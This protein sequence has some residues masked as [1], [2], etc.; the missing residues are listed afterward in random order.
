M[1][2]AVAIP[3]ITTAASVG[4]TLVGAKMGSNAA[5]N[6]ARTQTDAA[7]RAAQLQYDLGNRSLDFQRQMWETG[8]NDMMPWMNMGRSA[9]GTLGS[10]MGLGSGG[11][12]PMGG[13]EPRSVGYGQTP[14]AAANGGGSTL[15]SLGQGGYAGP[16]MVQMKAPNGE[17]RPVPRTMVEH[18]KAR[19]AQVVG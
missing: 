9:L 6:A 3:L 4:G 12:P 8:R 13:G 11:G 15:G 1:P 14:N 16:Q 17:V 19:G 10:R 5:N 7:N 2:A 18:Y